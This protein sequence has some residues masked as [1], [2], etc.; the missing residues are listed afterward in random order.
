[1]LQSIGSQ[2]VGQDSST[3]LKEGFLFFLAFFIFVASVSTQRVN[4]IEW[5]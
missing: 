5:S 1:M 4:T 3:E 2:R